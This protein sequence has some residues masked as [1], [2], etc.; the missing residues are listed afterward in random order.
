MNLSV[1]AKSCPICGCD[2]VVKEEK[3]VSNLFGTPEVRTHVYG[4]NWDKRTFLC[5]CIMCHDPQGSMDYQDKWSR[6]CYDPE[7]IKKQ[8]EKDRK[9]EGAKAAFRE[10]GIDERFAERLKYENI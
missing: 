9:I 8:K 3:E 4:G 10:L 7:V 5:G 1:K 6:C 2:I